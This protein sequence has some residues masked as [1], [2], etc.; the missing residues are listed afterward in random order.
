MQTAAYFPIA[1][2]VEDCDGLIDEKATIS[3][4]TFTSETWACEEGKYSPTKKAS[5][6]GEWYR[7][8]LRQ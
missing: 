4:K 6:Y 7:A 5:A 8:D 2:L 1:F 3:Y